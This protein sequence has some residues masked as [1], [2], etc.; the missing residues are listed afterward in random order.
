MHGERQLRDETRRLMRAVVARHEARARTGR[1]APSRLVPDRDRAMAVLQALDAGRPVPGTPSWS[2]I[3]R[4]VDR[5]LDGDELTVAVPPEVLTWFDDFRQPTMPGGG[6][7][8]VVVGLELAPDEVEVSGGWG[9][10]RLHVPPP[11][12]TTP[13]AMRTYQRLRADGT[14]CHV[15]A[16]LA[17]HL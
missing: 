1:R 8:Q 3:Q 4:A 12:V 11:D 6:R 2:D 9:R 10:R 5:D 17:R 14:P 7:L 15:A 13:A 16:D